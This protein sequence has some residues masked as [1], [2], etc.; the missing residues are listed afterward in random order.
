M[1]RPFRFKQFLIVQDKTPMKV[2]TDGVLLGAWA[3]GGRRI[4][5]VGVGTGV[6]A[7]MMAQRFAKADIVGID[8]C[9]DAIEEATHNVRQSQFCDRITIEKQDF[10]ELVSAAKYDTIICNPPYFE[11]SLK[12]PE[13]GRSMARHS[14]TL[15]LKE[16]MSKSGEMLMNSG[17]LNII[18]PYSLIDEAM[19]DA[20]KCGFV[21]RK[22]M[23][24]RGTK[25]AEW[26]RV[27]LCFEL[28]GEE[29]DWAM[30]EMTLEQERG[31]R[32]EAYQK[33]T[34]EFYMN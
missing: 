17:L 27:L 28:N 5:D 6:V 7:M 1:S 12:C 20:R 33:L 9:D 34:E 30:T 31:V 23:R 8:I 4:L 14:E 18:I 24:V 13:K 26:K 29:T 21:V 15:S 10:R 3:E 2:G 19:N 32:S 11:N 25:D 16:L 22:A